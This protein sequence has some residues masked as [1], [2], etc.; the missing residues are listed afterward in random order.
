MYS[1]EEIINRSAVEDEI[2]VGYADAMELLRILRGKT[3]RVLGWEGWVK[4]AD[5]SLGHSQEHQGTV[6]LS[7]NP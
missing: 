1:Y 5:G 3:T 2:V 4:Y 6:D 7:L